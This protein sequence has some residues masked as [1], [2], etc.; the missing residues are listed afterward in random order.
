MSCPRHEDLESY[1]VG[2]LDEP[3]HG[4]VESHLESCD[5]CLERLE[6]LDARETY[7]EEVAPLLEPLGEGSDLE[8]GEGSWPRL[9]GYEIQAE[10]QRGGQ[11]VIYAAIQ[12]ST[13][14]RVAIKTLILGTSSSL[15]HRRRFEREIDLVSKLN[16]PNIVTVF[17]RGQTDDGLQY[18]AM[19]WIEGQRLDTWFR[20]PGR[21]LQARLEMFVAVCEAMV[22]AHQQGIIH[23]D[24][25]PGNI[26]VDERGQPQILDF[27]LA[28]LEADLE[29][30]GSFKTF[31][32][33]LL[34]TL[35]YSSPEQVS[36]DPAAVDVRTDVYS[37]G[38]VLYEGLTERLPYSVRGSVPSVAR[39]IAEVE[40]QR[41]S[42]HVRD[43][44]R[45]LECIVLT[46]LEKRREDRYQSI[47][48]FI[49]DIE[50]YLHGR[51]VLAR[52]ASQ[53]YVLRKN[54][55]RHWLSV[56]VGAVL[57]A[58]LV[59]TTLV[60]LKAARD[61]KK[62]ERD[63]SAAL[64][65]ATLEEK[66]AR[67]VLDLI[68]STL[69][70]LSPYEGGTEIKVMDVF[71]EVA[72]TVGD[73]F[74]GKLE[75]R[76]AVHAALS[77]GYF[78]LGYYD[79]AAHHGERAIEL[80]RRYLPADSAEVLVLDVHL[81]GIE[82]RRQPDEEMLTRAEDLYQRCQKS[83]GESDTTLFA[84]S[85]VGSVLEAVGQ[86]EEALTCARDV[87][88]RSHSVFDEEPYEIWG[89]SLR[90]A[91]CESSA[92]LLDES[93]KRLLALRDEVRDQIA[94]DD[95]LWVSIENN[96][97]LLWWGLARL[98]EAI[99][100]WRDVVKARE[101]L[102]GR[103]HVVTLGAISNLGLGLLNI[104]AYEEAAPLIR[105]AK[106]GFESRL[107]LRH[108]R[109]LTVTQNYAV[110]LWKTGELEESVTCFEELIRRRRD[111]LG[112]GHPGTLEILGLWA[113]VLL[114]LG[115]TQEAADVFEEAQELL[116]TDHRSYATLAIGHHMGLAA[117]AEWEG[118]DSDAEEDLLEALRLAEEYW[119][120][121]PGTGERGLQRL[122]RRLIAFYTRMED[123]DRTSLYQAALD[124]IQ[125]SN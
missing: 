61:S 102:L 52:S 5:S 12:E 20:E 11:G 91:M 121:K 26:L 56:S 57:I 4:R 41:P 83:L 118:R 50:R 55:R 71:E 42:G 87:L 77:E 99:T 95:P 74:E 7:W 96:L 43:L 22:Y 16:H 116:E 21:T 90:L 115:R 13:G 39:T 53:W 79:E 64:E 10:V 2:D 103:D 88:S 36:G 105:D 80:S 66:T 35:A 29:E 84:L 44:A 1:L 81:M 37:L 23:R 28:K 125:S 62:A 114:E 45:D 60:S 69:G 38:V 108:E 76:V 68:L 46:S 24:L 124:A 9:E 111:V 119:I 59:V 3:Q 32:G 72:A 30:R 31:E 75:I 104:G 48:E 101:E 18:V 8:V 94:G 47:Q 6:S 82:V 97:A 58:A 85:H 73:S 92:G 54:L 33:E 40:P 117:C 17:D 14:R 113:G 93:E 27:G 120:A 98:D 100:L 70:K 25:K 15:R 51:P 107:G 65:K 63:I 19:K 78:E 122:Y 89:F 49:A 106:L 86:F 123:E 67:S 109:T 34:G 110:L 112:I